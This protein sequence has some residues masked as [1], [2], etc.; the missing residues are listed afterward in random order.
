MPNCNPCRSSPHRFSYLLNIK[1]KSNEP[2]KAG[3]VVMQKVSNRYINDQTR[4]DKVVYALLHTENSIINKNITI[5]PMHINAALVLSSYLPIIQKLYL[6]INMP[7]PLLVRSA[8]SEWAF[9]FTINPIT[10]P[11]SDP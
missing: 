3:R 8:R 4:C 7:T 2:C 11:I 10:Q 1:R 5:I 6:C 9:S